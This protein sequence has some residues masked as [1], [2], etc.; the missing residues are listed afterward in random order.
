MGSMSDIPDRDQIAADEQRIDALLR[1]VEA[2][3]PPGAAVRGSPRA[4]QA[5]RAVVAGGAGDRARASPGA[6][7]AA[8]V[9]LVLAAD[10]G[11]SPAAPTVVQASLIAL[12]RSTGSA[13]A[14]LVAAGTRIAF[15]DWSDRG[16]PR[17][18]RALDRVGGRT[19]TTEFYRAYA[20][21]AAIGYS[22]VSGAPL[23][24]GRAARTVVAR[25]R[26]LR[27]DPLR[28]RGDRHL[29]R[30]RPHV[31]PRVAHRLAGGAA[32][33]RDVAGPPRRPPEPDL[34]RAAGTAR[35]I[36]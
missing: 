3:A 20:G 1:A 36:G 12:E 2:S 9:A 19:V 29:G 7:S 13:P 28:R 22:I 27:R 6:A 33:A 5:R 26:A 17:A 31:H 21:R 15:P 18:R 25:R 23:R 35:L 10:L 4:T 16:W 30:G 11:G 14:T 24:W 8:C 34:E 32:G